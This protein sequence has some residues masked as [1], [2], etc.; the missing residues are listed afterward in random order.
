MITIQGTIENLRAAEQLK[1]QILEIWPD[2]EN[3]KEDRVLIHSGAYMPLGDV[4]DIDLV[5]I[6]LFKKE[7]EIEPT[8]IK[9]FKGEKDSAK[10]LKKIKVHSFCIAIECK[11]KDSK[12]VRV[13]GTEV[14]VQIY[15]DW[16]SA[17]HQN[18]QQRYAL[19][20]S[21]AREKIDLFITRSV[22]LTH[23]TI[24]HFESQ[25][26]I[27]YQAHFQDHTFGDMI[28]RIMTFRKIE[29]VD[30]KK[31]TAIVRAKIGVFQHDFEEH[32]EKVF[33]S[34]LFTIFEP[35]AIDRRKMESIKKIRAEDNHRKKWLED[36]GKKQIVFRGRGGTG[37]T[38]F[39]FH[40]AYKKS[41]QEEKRSLILT[42]NHALITELKR[43]RMILQVGASDQGIKIDSVMSFMHKIWKK[44]FIDEKFS[45]FKYEKHIEDL[46]QFMKNN[47][48][49]FDACVYNL[50]TK[51]SDS[52]DFD[53]IFVDEGQDWF[54]SEVDI[55]RHI[56]GHKNIV[57]AHGVAQLTRNF[58]EGKSREVSWQRG[59]PKSENQQHLLKR[60]LRMKSKLAEF[61]IGLN[62]ELGGYELEMEPN[63]TKE[64]EHDDQRVGGSI[65]VVEGDFFKDKKLNDQILSQSKKLGNENIDSL[66]CCSKNIKDKVNPVEKLREAGYLV[67]NGA[68]EKERREII[69]SN[70]TLRLVLFES[71]RGLEGWSVINLG[72]DDLWDQIY[73]KELKRAKSYSTDPEGEALIVAR[74]W[75]LIP[76]TRAIDTL[77]LQIE[78]KESKIGK[79]LHSMNEKGFIDDWIKA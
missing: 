54:Q 19:K 76:A 43:L 27:N 65:V 46:V 59:L 70:D 13:N 53:H 64:D 12:S 63:N 48:D 73:Q 44:V 68:D 3:D 37:K 31:T 58:Y 25:N 77:I 8:W 66:Y 40:I 57:V 56:Y 14:E 42:Y 38:V 51:F 24:K 33:D 32:I 21:L 5:L 20:N 7:R 11:K 36:I 9:E 67:W 61:V 2:L 28:Q 15:G 16:K 22:F 4:E 62:E 78:S 17:T 1:Q 79:H 18:H 52:F 71:C 49:E 30:G 41:T 39:M 74:N 47:R 35:T 55:L 69:K 75:L 50:M 45:I 60:A 26:N 6:G 72:F 34:E 29:Y 10:N 23:N